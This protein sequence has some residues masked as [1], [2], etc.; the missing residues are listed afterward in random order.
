MAVDRSKFGLYVNPKEKKMVRINSPHWFP[1]APEWV[2]LTPEVNMTLLKA[3]DMAA[4]KNIL[5]GDEKDLL[6]WGTLPVLD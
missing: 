4:Q 2:F 5:K 1:P 6:T 3:R